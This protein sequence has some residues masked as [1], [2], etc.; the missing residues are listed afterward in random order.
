MRVDHIAGV[1]IMIL[2][3]TACASDPKPAPA[4]QPRPAAPDPRICDDIEPEPELVGGLPQPV[5]PE[6]RDAVQAFFKG[7]RDLLFWGRHGWL[8]AT[9][10]RDQYCSP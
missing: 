3:L 6:E 4:I 7:E 9:L 5:T 2:A 8:R 10:A 1:G